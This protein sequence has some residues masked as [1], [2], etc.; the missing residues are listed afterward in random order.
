[1]ETK[2]DEMTM[3]TFILELKA[4]LVGGVIIDRLPPDGEPNQMPQEYIEVLDTI[5]KEQGR[6]PV[7]RHPKAIDMKDIPF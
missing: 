3:H 1:M 5:R 6:P 4:L 2:Y 7:D